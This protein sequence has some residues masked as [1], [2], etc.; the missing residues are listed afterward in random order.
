MSEKN[1]AKQNQP[2][3]N[4]TKQATIKQN[5]AKQNEIKRNQAIQNK[6]EEKTFWQRI[7]TIF[8]KPKSDKEVKVAYI[9]GIFTIIAAIITAIATIRAAPQINNYIPAPQILTAIPTKISII[10]T[11]TTTDTYTPES[12]TETAWSTPTLSITNTTIPTSIPTDSNDE[13]LKTQHALNSENST[14]IYEDFKATENAN[15]QRTEAIASATSTAVTMSSL[16]RSAETALTGV[17]ATQTAR[18]MITIPPLVTVLSP[19]TF[20]NSNSSPGQSAE[21]LA[22]ISVSAN[23]DWEQKSKNVNGIEMVLVPIG[24]F[25]MGTNES[26]VF[27]EK[28]PSSHQQCITNP[29][30]IGKYEITNAQYEQATG[31]PFGCESRSSHPNQ[32]R[33]CVTWFEAYEFCHNRG[34]RLPSE[35]EW[36]YTARGPDSLLF[37]WGNTFESNYIALE[38]QHT[39]TVGSYS[40]NVSWVGALDMIGNLWEW[41]NSQLRDYAYNAHDGREDYPIGAPDRRVTRGGSVKESA[42]EQ[43]YFYAPTRGGGNPY[44]EGSDGESNVGFRCVQPVS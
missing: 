39:A 27:G 23:N 10:P 2:K 18:A 42:T 4:Q 33:N 19:A 12:P 34:E 38:A 8:R 7:K 43:H 40:S 11:A 37:P 41:T 14:R 9:G 29:F 44:D 1:Q 15:L 30:W 21:E 16:T 36:E 28:P 25:T 5:Q 32:P 26:N 31:E 6:T 35:A 13:I 20:N 17:P 3:Q 24:C 22:K